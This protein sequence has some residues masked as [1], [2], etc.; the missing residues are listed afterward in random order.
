M[1]EQDLNSTGGVHAQLSCRALKALLVYFRRLRGPEQLGAAIASAGVGLDEEFLLDEDNW[2]E[3]DVAQRVLDALTDASGDPL[4]PRRAGHITA[5]R[6]VIG[7]GYSLLRSFGTPRMCF[8]R[9]V[10][11]SSVYNRVGTFEVQRL[12]GSQLALTYRSRVPEP[13]RRFCELRLAQFESF[14]TLWGVPPARGRETTCQTRGDPCCTYQLEWVNPPRLWR[15]LVGGA[16]LGAAGLA[17]EGPWLA[18]AGGIAGALAG[19]AFEYRAQVRQRDEIIREESGDVVRFAQSLTRR[20]E[21]IQELNRTLESRVDS[22]TRELKETAAELEKALARARELDQLKTRFFNNLN[23]DLRSPLTVITGALTN[24][25]IAPD[26]RQNAAR[27]H[28]VDLA[29]RSSSRLEAMINDLL[30]LGRIE[31]GARNLD[32]SRVDLVEVVREVVEVSQPFAAGH[33]LLLTAD[34]PAQALEVDVDVSKIE[35][36]LM[37]LL[38]NACK[39]SPAGKRVSV[40]VADADDK[41]AVAVT[42][43]GIGIPRDER[44]R[45]FERF[46]RGSSAEHQMVKGVGLGLSVVREFVGL[47]GGVVTLQSEV[48]QGST[49]TVY[50]PKLQAR[51]GRRTRIRGRGQQFA[52][53]LPDVPPPAA[54]PRGIDPAPPPTPV[55]AAAEGAPVARQAPEGAPGA[56]AMPSDAAHRAPTSP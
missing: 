49:F 23:H 22:R 42:D 38:T 7:G 6:D 56:D 45:V 25:A 37:N 34:L 26:V 3:F 28:L 15:T 41:V 29:L 53:L 24:L 27:S 9:A 50:L 17:A 40:R 19:T 10:E 8:R 33:G 18:L 47:H 51:P 35:R 44:A 13:N 16:L 21:E 12:T 5:S 1:S 43:Q 52:R 2:V 46:V 55:P 14:P 30:E 48:G 54:R 32:L 31:G 20:F 36:V 4:F 11:I 39:F